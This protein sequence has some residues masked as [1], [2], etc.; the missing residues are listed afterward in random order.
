[1]QA[2]S[3]THNWSHTVDTAHRPHPRCIEMADTMRQIVANY[4]GVSPDDLFTA[5]FSDAEIGAFATE[6]GKIALKNSE[7]QISNHHHDLSFL[8]ETAR[9]AAPNALPLPDGAKTTLAMQ[10]A[11]KVYCNARKAFSHY[12]WHLL[13]EMV[14]TELMAYLLIAPFTA[15][16]RT[17]II[18]AV[19]NTL[20]TMPVVRGAK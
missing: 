3:N 20:R 12:P 16:M 9:K 7:R 18:R 14:V 6:A 15:S 17:C 10:D 19:E 13:R 11:W 8:I 1:M 5:G 2:Q 4:G